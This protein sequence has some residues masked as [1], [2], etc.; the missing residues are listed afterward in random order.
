MPKPRVVTPEKERAWLYG[1]F[2]DATNEFLYVG[3]TLNPYYRRVAHVQGRLAKPELQSP[4]VRYI[5]LRQTTARHVSRI[6]SQIIRCLQRRGQCRLNRS[7]GS[8]RIRSPRQITNPIECSNGMTFI[9]KA[10]AA[11]YFDVSVITIRNAFQRGG[12]VCAR[13]GRTYFIWLK[14]NAQPMA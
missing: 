9:G 3:Q 11:R 8:P 14:T 1:F 4:T 6:E 13:N 12:E 10:Q 7:R 5:V 2:D